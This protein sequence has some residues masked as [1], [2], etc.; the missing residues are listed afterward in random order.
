MKRIIRTAALALTACMLAAACSKV[1]RYQEDTGTVTMSLDGDWQVAEMTR[2]SVSDYAD[3]PSS[4]DFSIV[5]VNANDEEIPVT[6]PSEPL[7]LTVGNYIARASYGSTADE[8]F[9]KPCFAGEQNFIIEGGKTTEVKIVA[10][11][12]NCLVKMAYTDAFRSYYSDWS[13]TLT[14]G[15]G[16]SIGFAADETRAAFVDAYL[17]KVKGTLTTQGGSTRTFEETEYRNLRPATCYTM[18]F[19]ASNIGQDSITITFDDSVTTV[20]LGEVELND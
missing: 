6:N 17:V 1:V 18:K 16:N 9:G 7:K 2:S 4:G 3:L 10:S 11:L 20:E 5:V 14:T 8:G 13:F 19:D 15:S 12:A